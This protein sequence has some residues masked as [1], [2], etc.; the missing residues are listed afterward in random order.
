MGRLRLAGRGWSA[1]C[2]GR[3]PLCGAGSLGP[4]A[5]AFVIEGIRFGPDLRNGPR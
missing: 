4:M 5:G 3:G 2:E 1:G